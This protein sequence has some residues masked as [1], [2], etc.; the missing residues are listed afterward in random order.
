MVANPLACST[1]PVRDRAACSALSE[2]ERDE[3]ARLGRRR[4]LKRG[5]TLFPAGATELAC[6]TLITGALKMSSF[7]E[8]GTE[9][10]LGLVHPAGFVGEMFAPVAEHDVIALTDSQLC[11]FAAEGYAR[12][13]ER[14]PALGR[15]LLRRSNED[16]FASRAMINLM[17]RRTARQKV[18]G[19]LLSMARAASDSPCHPSQ[20]FD[21]PLTRGEI[22]GM[23][24]T[25]IETVSRQL[26]AL[27]GE[28]VIKR[29]GARGIRI[30]NLA[31]LE[32]AAA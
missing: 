23:L 3:L 8:D 17:G 26:S 25:T 28:A 2:A 16:L 9:R 24:G 18:A 27:E 14:F 11:V 5:E 21:L 19:F 6:A 15:A 10:I 20:L 4:N 13:I 22:A 29:Q 32:A 7:G 1:C 12:A 30:T 31:G